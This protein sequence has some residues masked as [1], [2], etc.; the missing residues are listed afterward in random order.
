MLRQ[1]IY[2]KTSH[3]EQF[4]SRYIVHMH[5]PLPDS[6]MKPH[7]VKEKLP[8]AEAEWVEVMQDLVHHTNMCSEMQVIQEIT[9]QNTYYNNPQFGANVSWLGY[10]F[11]LSIF[12]V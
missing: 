4:A 10:I 12:V 7:G 11:F 9:L 6:H 1:N 5:Q 3:I 2:W 8:L